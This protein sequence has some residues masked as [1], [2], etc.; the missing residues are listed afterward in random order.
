MPGV[1]R[2][3]HRIWTKRRRGPRPRLRWTTGPPGVTQALAD[4]SEAR[5]SNEELHRKERPPRG[6]AH[7]LKSGQNLV[8]EKLR[9]IGHGFRNFS[10][11]WLRLL[12]HSGVEWEVH[13]T[14]RIT[15]RRPHLVA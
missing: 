11:Y 4:L 12:L 8:T 7:P 5:L 9:R 10:N 13:P 6:I 15:S 1:R 3:R 14:A 2:D